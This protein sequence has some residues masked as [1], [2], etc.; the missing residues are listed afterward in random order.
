MW[1]M[2]SALPVTSD[3][4]SVLARFGLLIDHCSVDIRG[5]RSI[6][7][8]SAD[9]CCDLSCVQL[10]SISSLILSRSRPSVSPQSTVEEDP[11]LS[12]LKRG[13]MPSSSIRVRRRNPSSSH[14][15]SRDI[16]SSLSMQH[17]I[18]CTPAC[19]KSG[20][21]LCAHFSTRCPHHNLCH[22]SVDYSNPP[23]IETGSHLILAI[24][25][26]VTAT[27]SGST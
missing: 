20:C 24:L 7:I 2:Q 4:G 23:S 16:G 13:L 9:S 15:F 8:H 17:L 27:T 21:Q 22:R 18:S 6:G 26:A 5:A 11:V 25:K 19:I 1:R 3:T 12:V 14:I 10:S